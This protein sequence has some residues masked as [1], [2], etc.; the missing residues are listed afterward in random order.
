MSF[1]FIPLQASAFA[2][3]SGPDTG[4]ASSIFNAQ[5]QM[6]AALANHSRPSLEAGVWVRY[7]SGS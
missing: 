1:V 7:G 4:R 3:I 5:R 6:S 2:R